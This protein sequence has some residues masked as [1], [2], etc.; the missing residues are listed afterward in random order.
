MKI[1]LAY[2]VVI[3]LVQFAL[4]IGIMI[5]GFPIALI[6]AWIPDRF[7]IP[8]RAFVAG[9]AGAVM[10]ICFGFVVFTW[11]AGAGSFSVF[12]FLATAIPLVIPIINDYHK[13]RELKELISDENYPERVKEYAT[14][15][16]QARGTAV[17][18][19]VV[20]IIIGGFWLIT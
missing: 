18:G 16:T 13:Y 19:E 7:G 5:L 11:L 6:L 1:A 3:P 12:P 4:T 10:S 14:P 20:G 17:L 15:D 8:I 9:C 2:L